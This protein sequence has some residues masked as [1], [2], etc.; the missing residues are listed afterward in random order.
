L[1]VWH[2]IYRID[3]F[4]GTKIEADWVN[5]IP[6]NAGGHTNYWSDKEVLAHIQDIIEST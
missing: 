1:K 5:N 3:D 6:V 2:N 4:V